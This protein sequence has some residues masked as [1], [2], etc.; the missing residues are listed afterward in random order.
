MGTPS[1]CLAFRSIFI[2][3]QGGRF[4]NPFLKLFYIKKFPLLGE[5]GDDFARVDVYHGVSF[6]ALFHHLEGDCGGVFLQEPTNLLA[7]GHGVQTRVGQP[8]IGINVNNGGGVGYKRGHSGGDDDA[9]V[10]VGV[11]GQLSGHGVPSFRGRLP[12]L[13]V[14]L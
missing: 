5:H 7:G 2:I 8:T 3:A 4:V 13:M 10:C 6:Y 1:P 11:G 12:S 14:L 9:G